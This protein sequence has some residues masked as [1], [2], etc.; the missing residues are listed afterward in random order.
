MRVTSWPEAISP[1]TASAIRGKYDAATFRVAEHRYPA[2]TSFPGRTR[3]ATWFVLAGACK[4]TSGEEVVVTA[5]QVVEI[6][7]GDFALTVVGDCELHL[8]QVWDLR[9]F[10]N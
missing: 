7:A 3:A 4:V 6:E 1:M 5:G 8:V 2:G 9:P 10:M